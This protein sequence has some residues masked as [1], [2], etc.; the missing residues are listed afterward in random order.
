M[1]RFKQELSFEECVEVLEN[2]P[3]G[4][5]S[6][7]G[8]DGYPYAFPMNQIYLNG[9]LYFHSGKGGYKLE[10]IDADGKA[11]FC[12][13]DEGFQKEGDWALN[14]KSVIVFG[15]VR[16]TDLD[17]E[18]LQALKNLMK[19]FYPMPLE[20]ADIENKIAK[21]GPYVQMLEMTI[22]HMTGKLVNE[23]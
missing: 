17:G 10:S 16:K 11:S 6:L 21:D 15:K 13:M 23:S 22:E 3:R 4:V 18:A 19:K 5:L 8:D 9:K 14:I 1:R 2:A 20:S 12:A 7:N